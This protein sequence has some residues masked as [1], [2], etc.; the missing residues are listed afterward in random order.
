MK[1]PNS[2]YWKQRFE[3]VNEDILNRNAKEMEKHIYNSYTY[4]LNNIE[5]DIENLISR[6]SK[7]SGISYSDL[8]K[9]LNSKDLKSFRMTLEEY[10]SVAQNK[11]LSDEWIK[12]LENA[13][14]ISRIDRL[15]MLKIQMSQQL[16]I[17]AKN[18][19]DIFNS[20]LSKVY[21]ESYYHSIYE[22]Q[23]GFG[24]GNAFATLD[25][26]TIN[27]VLKKPWTSDLKTFS[28]RIWQDKETLINQ[29]QTT[30][31]QG[32]I[33]GAALEKIIREIQK[34]T[35]SS[36]SASRRLVLTESAAFSSIARCESYKE[37]NVERYSI[38]ATLDLKTSEICRSLDGKEFELSEY[39][40]GVTAP[41]FH[42]H[43]RT[44][45][46]PA[47]NDEF[48]EGEER[49]ARD[50]E[51]N[52]YYVPSDMT[53]KEWKKKYVDEPKNRLN[54]FK[55]NSSKQILNL[56]DEEKDVIRKYTGN[57]AYKIN[58]LLGRG[59]SL[60]KSQEYI[61]GLK[62]ALDKCVISEDIIV[63]RKQLLEHLEL[64]YYIINGVKGGNINLLNGRIISNKTFIS[65]SLV[66]FEHTGRN[67]VV[68][69]KVPK[70]YKGGLYIKELAYDKYKYQEEVLFNIGLKYKI[71]S[72]KIKGNK[73]YIE[74]EVINNA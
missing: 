58:S 52:G 47:F 1:T 22:L 35:G 36:Y 37:L 2:T 33:R 24:Y 17:L 53:F 14:A 74:A 31:T 23:K 55:E 45:T 29:L 5:K 70:G 10:I 63:I 66:D 72:A 6:I 71:T 20:N 46:I 43:C 32:I 21:S 62:N 7:N 73:Y 69:L 39:E 16:E 68:N 12:R 42:P 51:G 11:G 38:L 60:G 9:N 56:S 30:F 13:S 54:R 48:T 26:K 28:D 44:T 18:K 27:E 34:K 19:N 61:S 4:A 59:E 40:T 57:T 67:V 3:A 49:F 41:P 50:E 15:E 8:K 64:P 25:T 65:T